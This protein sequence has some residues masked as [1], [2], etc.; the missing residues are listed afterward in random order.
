M[1]VEDAVDTD[2][3]AAIGGASDEGEVWRIRRIVCYDL[4]SS[5]A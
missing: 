2:A 5:F 4:H 1:G 3:D